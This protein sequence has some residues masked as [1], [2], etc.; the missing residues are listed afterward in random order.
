MGG[1]LPDA[2]LIVCSLRTLPSQLLRRVFCCPK[3]WLIF[4]RPGGSRNGRPGSRG[5]RGDARAQARGACRRERGASRT[6]MAE[7]TFHG[8]QIAARRRQRRSNSFSVCRNFCAA[9]TN[10]GGEDVGYFAPGK[11]GSTPAFG[12]RTVERPWQRTARATAQV[13]RPM[14]T[15]ACVD[16]TESRYRPFPSVPFNCRCSHRH[17]G[18]EDVCY[19]G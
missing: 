6:P 11:A 7:R 14:R 17:G 5:S 8:S 9:Q 4:E 19:F 16:A 18:G 3:R 12:S 15:G 10:A 2:R 13:S 1:V